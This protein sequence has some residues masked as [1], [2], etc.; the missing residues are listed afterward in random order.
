MISRFYTNRVKLSKKKAP[1][2]DPQKYKVYTMEREWI[3]TSVNVHMILPDLR[4]VV[5]NACSRYGIERVQVRLYSKKEHVFGYVKDE[6]IYLNTKFHGDNLGVLLHELAHV[7]TD[8][9]HEERE[10]HGPM[11]CLIYGELLDF[12]KVLP[13]RAFEYFADKWDVAIGEYY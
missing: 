10:S 1:R 13:M 6:V 5:N 11:F 3:G 9:K 8:E 2:D 4:S 12:Y 7:I